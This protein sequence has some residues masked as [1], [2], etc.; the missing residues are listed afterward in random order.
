MLNRSNTTAAALLFAVAL[1]L[2]G[3]TDAP[4]RPLH[5]TPAPT[6]SNPPAT[7]TAEPPL[8]RQ[9]PVSIVSTDAEVFAAA[10]AAYSGYIRLDEELLKDRNLPPEAMLRWTTPDFGASEMRE[11]RRSRAAGGHLVGK[12]FVSGFYLL[13][14]QNAG[15]KVRAL[16]FACADASQSRFLDSNGRNARD[17]KSALRVAVE[18]DLRQMAAGTSPLVVNGV[19]GVARVG[20]C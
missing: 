19:D 9:I 14:R 6:H 1:L 12:L 17:P 7:N 20:K 15:G 13:S 16:L 10:T 3:C 11:L 8:P 4:P 2:Q 5:L 18:V